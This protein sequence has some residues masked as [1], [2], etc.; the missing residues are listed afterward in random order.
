MIS[1]TIEVRGEM[2]RC[3]IRALTIHEGSCDGTASFFLEN[4]CSHNKIIKKQ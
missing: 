1:T 3:M 4:H 2:D